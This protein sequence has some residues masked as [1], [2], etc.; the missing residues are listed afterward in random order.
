MLEPLAQLDD[1]KP[2]FTS[3]SWREY[4]KGRLDDNFTDR[5]VEDIQIDKFRI[6]EAG[7]HD[8]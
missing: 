3:F 6:T 1:G 8:L 4:I 2:R 5:G 7:E